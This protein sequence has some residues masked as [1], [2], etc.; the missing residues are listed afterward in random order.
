MNQHKTNLR[1]VS[2]ATPQGTAARVDRN[3]NR[4]ASS[5]DPHHLTRADQRIT[6]AIKPIEVQQLFIEHL[7]CNDGVNARAESLLAPTRETLAQFQSY[8]RAAGNV[9]RSRAICADARR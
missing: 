2:Y 6:A 5:I 9:Q 7:T 1:E 8:R 4:L 3:A